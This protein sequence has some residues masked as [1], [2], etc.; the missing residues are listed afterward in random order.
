VGG[1]RPLHVR[2]FPSDLQCCGG[3]RFRTAHKEKNMHP[4]IGLIRRCTMPTILV[5]AALLLP[6]PA[7]ADK[8][9]EWKFQP[10][11]TLHYTMNQEINQ[12]VSVGGKALKVSGTQTMD[13]SWNVKSVQQGVASVTQTLDRARMKL[14]QPGATVEY[15]SA[16]AK[17][18]EGMAR[19]IAPM[20]QAL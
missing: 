19:L 10:G 5:A 11:E 1:N 18:P 16:A 17:E 15:D 14:S 3:N 4:L 20:F 8:K 2:P 12:E 7:R 9:L 13:I 6:A